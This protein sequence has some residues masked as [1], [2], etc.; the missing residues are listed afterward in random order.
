M[1]TA[2]DIGTPGPDYQFGCG[3]IDAYRAYKLIQDERFQKFTINQGD[4]KE[5]T[6]QIPDGLPIAKFMIYW[7]EMESALMARKALINDLDFEIVD[8][9]GTILL[10]GY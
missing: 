3:V 7:P 4:L 6:I 5:F 10:P 2:T 1:N 8:P 9:N